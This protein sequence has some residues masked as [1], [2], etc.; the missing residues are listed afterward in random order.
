LPLQSSSSSSFTQN[1]ITN[2]FSKKKKLQIPT[3]V[4]HADD[5]DGE[6]PR[7]LSQ[8]DID[9]LTTMPPVPLRPLVQPWD[10]IEEEGDEE[11][12]D[13]GYDGYDDYDDYPHPHHQPH[14]HESHLEQLYQQFPTAV[15]AIAYD[16]EDIDERKEEYNDR[17]QELRGM[18]SRIDE[19][20]LQR[21]QL[22]QQQQ[23]Q[24]LRR[25]SQQQDLHN[26]RAMQFNLS[27]SGGGR[28]ESEDDPY[29][30]D[31]PIGLNVDRA[32]LEG[33]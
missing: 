30:L 18:R 6:P 10:D 23:H 33:L 19:A 7:I 9:Y 4:I 24:K 25:Q 26:V 1:Y 15:G 28:F 13:D 21:I 29:A 22:Q 5:E 27:K 32:D 11:L 8:Q 3:I 20:Q 12:Y 14:Y 31:V 17:E 16:D 2:A